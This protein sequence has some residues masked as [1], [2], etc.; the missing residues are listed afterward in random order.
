MDTTGYN[1]EGPM[2]V[3][4][5]TDVPR[6][7]GSPQ[8]VDVTYTSGRLK[9]R[10]DG[11]QILD[12][13]VELP[14]DVLVGFTAATS[15]APTST[16]SA[17]SSSR[18]DWHGGRSARPLTTECSE[19]PGSAMDD[20]GSSPQQ[21]LHLQASI[22]GMCAAFPRAHRLAALSPPIHGT[23]ALAPRGRAATRTPP[24]VDTLVC[25]WPFM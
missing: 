3:E 25:C 4:T 10:I 14:P 1:A 15:N 13:A 21:L 9:V 18:Q 2:W 19:G 8:Q 17:T 22:P 24:A 16:P 11:R 7:V 6:L 23:T 20:P 5:T 12:T